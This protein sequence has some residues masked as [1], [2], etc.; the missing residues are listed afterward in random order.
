MIEARDQQTTGPWA[1][2]VGRCMCFIGTQPVNSFTYRLWLLHSI[3]ADVSIHDR[4]HGDHKAKNIYYLTLY[5]KSL[6]TPDLKQKTGGRLNLMM[7]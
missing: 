3:T 4:G 1:E 6:L 5:L 2:F 7:A